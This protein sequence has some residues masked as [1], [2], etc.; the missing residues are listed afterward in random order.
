MHDLSF[1]NTLKKKPSDVR[2]K[3]KIKSIFWHSTHE[4][5]EIPV[6]SIEVVEIVRLLG[7]CHPLNTAENKA[8]YCKQKV[9]WRAVVNL[10]KNSS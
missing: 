6:S 8:L 1:H 4:K 9:Q 5:L 7:V 2:F 10:H 3:N